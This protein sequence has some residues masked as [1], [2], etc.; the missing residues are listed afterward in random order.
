ME[1]YQPLLTIN[2]NLLF[3]AVTIIVLFIILKVFFFE[4]VHKFMMDRENEIRSSIENADNVNKLADEK[5]Q[6]YEAKIANVEMESR[7]MLK[8]AR[9][10]AKVQAKEIV[11]S[12]NEKARN[13]IDHSQKEIRREQYN[14]RKELKEEVGNLAMMAAEQ[15]LEKELSPETHEEIINKIIEEADEK[16]WS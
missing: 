14:A 13:L 10:E 7:Q 1:M 11:D 3:T 5:L 2:W 4:K 6:N 12:A 15:I 8:A 9:D 16:P